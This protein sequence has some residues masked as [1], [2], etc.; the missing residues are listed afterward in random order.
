[1]SES[2][3]LFLSKLVSDNRL[4]LYLQLT[5]FM[6]G[7]SLIFLKLGAVVNTNYFSKNL[8]DS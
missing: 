8:C 1:M 5:S 7:F 6:G 2:R 4:L 3:M